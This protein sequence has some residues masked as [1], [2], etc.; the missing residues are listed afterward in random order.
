MDAVNLIYEGK[1]V[2][3][4][5]ELCLYT[6]V[7]QIDTFL[8]IR[9]LQGLQNFKQQLQQRH[10][11]PNPIPTNPPPMNW[12]QYTLT[13]QLADRFAQLIPQIIE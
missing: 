5:M 2:L 10:L 1:P 8:N 3:L 13:A 4:F 9:T 12:A 6:P 7:D 11:M